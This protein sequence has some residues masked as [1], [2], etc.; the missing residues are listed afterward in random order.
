MGAVDQKVLDLRVVPEWE[1]QVLQTRQED[2]A[3]PVSDMDKQ[4][5]NHMRKL[6]DFSNDDPEIMITDDNPINEYCLSNKMKWEV[7]HL[8]LDRVVKRIGTYTT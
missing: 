2:T 8:A 7:T 3:L 6:Y 5:A 4:L 1:S